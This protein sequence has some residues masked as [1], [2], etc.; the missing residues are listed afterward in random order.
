MQKRLLDINPEGILIKEI[1]DI[2]DELY[3]ITLIKTQQQTVAKTLFKQIERIQQ[4]GLPRTPRTPRTPRSRTPLSSPKPAT[5][6]D[7][8][9]PEMGQ[10]LGSQTDL[11]EP[12]DWTSQFTIDLKESMENQL[13]ELAYLK[14]A[15][16]H[17]SNAVRNFFQVTDFA[18]TFQLK[19][20]LDLKQQQAGV[21]EA[22]EAVKQ[23][24]ETLK[25]GRSIM[26]FTIVTIVF[27]SLKAKF[28]T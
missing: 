13:A 28:F 25:Q 24:K 17:T 21:V 2:L 11:L 20:L 4:K 22:R 12:T 27:V 9:L 19:D 18:N 23:A 26:L 8:S 3:I 15:A 5:V 6:N 14:E 7:F 10:T 16:E 1:K